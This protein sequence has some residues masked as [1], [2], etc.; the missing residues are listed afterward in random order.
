MSVIPFLFADFILSK[1]SSVAAVDV[2]NIV[3]YLDIDV[4]TKMAIIN[5]IKERLQAVEQ[6]EVA[7][8]ANESD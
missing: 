6:F 7:Y 5:K 3:A 2:K 8:S 4:K 1:R